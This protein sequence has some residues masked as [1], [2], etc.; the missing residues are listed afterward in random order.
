VKIW[1]RLATAAAGLVDQ[2][3]AG[4]AAALFSQCAARLE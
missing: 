3:E 2:A 4:R 1:R